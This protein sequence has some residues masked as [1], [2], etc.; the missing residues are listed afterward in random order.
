[1]LLPQAWM[2]GLGIDVAGFLRA[3]AVPDANGGAEHP[4]VKAKAVITSLEM[5]APANEDA[6]SSVTAEVS[7]EPEV[8]DTTKLEPAA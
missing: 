7:G 1:M 5:T 8:F 6:T 4:Y 2:Q 3:S